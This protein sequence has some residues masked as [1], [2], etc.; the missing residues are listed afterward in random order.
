MAAASSS[1][2]S[3]TAVTAV[4]QTGPQTYTANF[5][6]DWVIGQ[7][8]HGGYVTATFLRVA[9]HHFATTLHRQNQPHTLALHL[10]FL[11]RTQ[12]GPATFTVRELKLGRQTSVV[13][14][15]LSQDGREE[16]VGTLTQSNLA[17]ERGA[18]FDTHWQASPPITP[19]SSPAVLASDSDPLW[20]ERREW[21]QPDFRKACTHVRTW[22]PRGGQAKPGLYDMWTR[23]RNPDERWTNASL[24]YLV[25]MFPQVLETFVLDGVDRYAPDFDTRYSE[26]ERKRIL[27]K[28][29]AFW[30]PTLLLN[31]EVKKALPEEGEEFLF[32]RIQAKAIRNGRYDL[33]IVVLDG[34][35]EIVALSHHVVFALSAERNLAKRRPAGESAGKL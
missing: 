2:S 6:G 13:A 4:E 32:T 31:L 16:V 8:P 11:R 29:T 18:T 1:T 12:V 22:F 10:D 34:K 9:Q 35:R 15:S 3:I 24:G 33:E 27:G 19:L 5:S 14:I 25:D 30:F 7:V 21:P 23:F 26:Q 28:N 17:T 20:Q